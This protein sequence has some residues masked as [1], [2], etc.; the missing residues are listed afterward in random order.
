MIRP[1]N[2]VEIVMRMLFH[3]HSRKFFSKM[4]FR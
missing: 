2:A 4:T 1:V 3:S